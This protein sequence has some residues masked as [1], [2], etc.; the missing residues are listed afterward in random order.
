MVSD[1]ENEIFCFTATDIICGTCAVGM[2]RGMGGGGER[3]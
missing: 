2:E 1:F 3:F